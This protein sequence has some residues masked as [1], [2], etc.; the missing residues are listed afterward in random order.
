MKIVQK[1]GVI[2]RVP[3]PKSP[4]ELEAEVDDMDVEK[5]LLD[6]I[7]GDLEDNGIVQFS[8]KTVDRDFLSL[9]AYLD[10]ESAQ[11][12]GRYLHTFTQQ[13]VWTRTLLARVWVMLIEAKE[14]LDKQKA[15]VYAPLPVKMSVTEKEL[16]LYTNS[17]ACK[18]MEKVKEISAK[19]SM[20]DSYMKNLEDIIFD[21]S[22]E[23]SRRGMDSSGFNRAENMDVKKRS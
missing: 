7:E 1:K 14:E 15:L 8:N 22:R 9:P 5:S 18:A 4:E 21:V 6:I 19:Y 13:R 17:D 20:L 2:K 16:S 10:E 12:I 11:N 23:I 3:K